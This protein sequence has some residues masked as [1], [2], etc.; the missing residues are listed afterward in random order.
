MVG[1][2]RTANFVE[3]RHKATAHSRIAA[4]LAGKQNC[5]ACWRTQH[6]CRGQRTTE[7]KIHHGTEAEAGSGHG[8]CDS[9]AGWSNTALLQVLLEY[10]TVSS[11][12]A[13]S[14]HVIHPWLNI[15][16]RYPQ[17]PNYWWAQGYSKGDQENSPLDVGQGHYELQCASSHSDLV[18]SSLDR[19]Y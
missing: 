1:K 5:T 14:S 12:E 11:L 3:T 16:R 19:A 8:C 9:S 15:L 10:P 18:P 7:K 17:S 2:E 6:R 13:G 4:S